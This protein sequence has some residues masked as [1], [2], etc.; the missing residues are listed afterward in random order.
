MNALFSG[1][2][3]ENI[4]INRPRT[5]TTAVEKQ[6]SQNQVPAKRHLYINSKL[7]Y[8]ALLPQHTDYTP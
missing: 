8:F 4:K 7:T 5:C 1:W 6:V 3:R 2:Q